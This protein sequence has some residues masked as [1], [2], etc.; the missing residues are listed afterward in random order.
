MVQTV[1]FLVDGSFRG[2]YIKLSISSLG[3]DDVA[4]PPVLHEPGVSLLII[5]K[6]LIA[7]DGLHL[8]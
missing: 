5:S 4:S 1:N 2:I 6:Y 3:I 7:H 8:P